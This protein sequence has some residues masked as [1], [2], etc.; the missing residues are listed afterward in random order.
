MLQED[1]PKARAQL[2]GKRRELLERW[3]KGK[4][5]RTLDSTRI[6]RRAERGRAPLSFS[7]LRLWFL[8]QLVPG[9]A[10]YLIPMAMR[11][12]GVLD[13]DAL[14]VSLK[15]LTR[16]HEILRTSFVSVEGQPSQVITPELVITLPLVNLKDVAERERDTLVHKFVFEESQRPFN[17][18]EAPLWR[19]KLLSLDTDDHVL[20]LMM[21]HII[22]DEWSLGVLLREVTALYEALS[23]GARPMLPELPIQYADF[24]AWQGEW[25]QGEECRKQLSYWTN[26]LANPLAVLELPTDSPRPTV[27]SFRGDKEWLSFPPDLTR[28]LKE[29]SRQQ[30]AT[31][32]MTLLTA[33]STLLHRYTGQQS[34]IVG[35]PVA[36]RNRKETEGL[37]GCFVNTLVL[38]TDFSGDPTF[39]E[40]LLRVRKT[41]IDAYANQDLPFEKLVEELQPER[42]LSRNPLCDVFFVFQNTPMPSLKLGG[43]ALAPMQVDH[44]TA[45]LDLTL[46]LSEESDTL[47]GYLEY[48]ADLFLA[49]TIKR[50]VG[51]LNILLE[52]L[53]ANPHSRVSALPL[54]TETE[55]RQLVRWNETEQ[56]YPQSLCLHQLFESQVELS[57]RAAALI[58]DEQQITYGE[59]NCKANQLAHHL[60]GLGVGPETIVAVCMKR[61]IEMVIGLLGILKAG[62]AYLPLDPTYPKERLAFMLSDAG[63]PVVLTQASFKESLPVL[64]TALVCLDADWLRIAQHSE[65]NPVTSVDSQNLAYIIYTSGSTGEPKGVQVQHASVVN[66]SQ[67]HQNVYSVGPNDRATQVARL[68]FDASVWEIWPYLT[69]GASVYLADEW[70][71]T[72]PA[73]IVQWLV[74]NQI[75]ISFLPTPLAHAVLQ[76][77]WSPATALRTMLTGGDVLQHITDAS[78]PF[79]LVNNYGPT[80][81]TVVATWGEVETGDRLRQPSIG[82]PIH[83]TQVH[84]LDQKLGAVPVGVT[85]EIYLGG[86]GLAR[87]YFNRAD[88][89]AERFVP[90]PFSNK[91]GV[92]LYKTGDLGSYLADGRIEFRGRVDEQVKI[93]GYRIEPMEIETAL[94]QHPAV[95]EAVVI[96]RQDESTEKRLIG[97]L[98]FRE[99]R[100]VTADT[101]RN[102]LKAKLPD[103]MIPALFVSLD[104]LPLTPSGKIDRRALPAPDHERPSLK[105]KFVGART[106]AEK[107]LA[108]IWCQ[109]LG[110]PQV[111][112]HDNFFELG[113]DSILSIQIIARAGKAGFRFTPQQ[114]F[115]H[116]TIA[117]LVAV[118]GVGDGVQAEQGVVTGPVPLTP[119]QRWFFEQEIVDPHHYNQGLMLEVKRPLDAARLKDAID[120]LLDHHDGLRLRFERAAEGWRQVNAESA[121]SEVLSQIDEATAAVLQ[122]SLN[123]S[124]GPLLRVA[125]GGRPA[126]LLLIAHHL[127]VDAVSWRILLEDLETVYRQ[128][129]L[130]ERVELPAKTTAFKQW[131]LRLEDYARSPDVR[132]EASYWLAMHDTQWLGLPVDYTDGENTIASEREVTVSIDTERT[133]VLL[134]EVPSVYRTQIN[135]ILLTALL[136]AYARWSGESKLLLDLEGHGREPVFDDLDVTRTIGWFTTIFPVLLEFEDVSQPGLALKTIKEQLRKIPRRG[137]GYGVL[138]YLSGDEEIERQLR[139]LPRAEV[140]FNY[141]GQLDQ[142]TDQ[143]T[144]FSLSPWPVGPTR[145]PRRTREH[146]LE[147][148]AWISGGQLQL[149]W[150][151][152]E[153]I[154]RRET[155]DKLAE[156]FVEALLSLIAHC[157]SVEAGGYTPS[158]FPLAGLGQEALDR[159]SAANRQIEDIYPLSP[160]QQGMLF[161]SLSEP[162]SGVYVTQLSCELEGDLDVDAFELAWQEVINQHAILRTWIAWEGMT[163]PLQVVQR[164]VELKIERDDW[165][166]EFKFSEAPL[167][168]LALISTG[169]QAYQFV[170]SHHHLLLDGWSRAAVLEEVFACYLEKTQG[171]DAT[172]RARRPYRDYIEWLRRQD[173][174]KAKEYWQRV[175]KGFE[176]A[177][178]IG[179]ERE[180]ESKEGSTAYGEEHLNL[181]ETLT[182]KIAEYARSQHLTINSLAL[183]AWAILISRYSG[184]RE[185]LFGTTL[186]GRSMPIEELDQMVGLFINTLP[187]RVEVRE[188]ET[189][190]D[191][192]QYVQEL[193]AEQQLYEY[194]S[195]IQVQRWSRQHRMKLFDSI[196]VFENYPVGAGLSEQSAIEAGLQIRNVR[197][198]E[199]T[200]YPLAVVIVPGRELSLRIGYDQRLYEEHTIRLMLGHLRTILEQLATAEEQ[201]LSAVTLLSERERRETLALCRP[202]IHPT[203]GPALCLHQ[204][205]ELCAEK[206]P[207]AIAVSAEGQTLSYAELNRRANQLAHLLQV[208]GI[209]PEALVVLYLERSFEMIVAM[210]AVLKAGGAYVPL[211]AATP[212]RRVAFII[213]DTRATVVITNASLRQQLPATGAMVICLEEQPAVL[214]TQCAENPCSPVF[215]GNA[216]YV[217]YTSGSTGMPKG[218]LVTHGNVTRLFTATQAAY[219]FC[220]R[221]VWTQF[222]S[223]GFDFSVWEIWGALLYGGR[224]VIVPQAVTRSP[225]EFYRLLIS[226]GVTVLNQT[227]SAFRQLMQADEHVHSTFPLNLRLVIFGGEALDSRN[228]RG[229]FMRHGDRRPQLVNM[230]GITETTVHVTY[231]PLGITDTHGSP[232]GTPL[233]DLSVYVLDHR[234]E[235][236]PVSIRGELY[237]GGA[238]VARG[239]LHRPELTAERFVPDPFSAIEGA[240]LYKSGDVV[241]LRPEGELEYLGRVDQQIKVRGFR[242]EP[243]EIESALGQH[244]SVHEAAVLLREDQAQDKR[245][246]AY[247]VLK[248]TKTK[249]SVEELRR[250]LSES[251]PEY[252]LPSA[253]VFL[254]ELPLTSN[255][256]RDTKALLAMEGVHAEMDEEYVEPQNEREREL[257]KIWERVLGLDQVGINDN[258]FDLGGD[259]ILSL[260][261]LADARQLDLDFS[262]QQLFRHPTI[263]QLVRDATANERS[264]VAHPQTE[265]FSLISEADRLQL[266]RGI[267]DAYPLA[268]LQTGMLFH[269]VY[270]EDSATYH[271]V[272]SL[273]LRTHLDGPK[274][275][276]AVQQLAA[277]HPVLRTSFDLDRF[278]EPLQLIH[279]TVSIPGAIED[280][281]ALT[282]AEQERSLA[283]FFEEERSRRF[284]WT[285]PPLLRFHLHRLSDETFQLSWTEHHAILDGWSLASMLTELFQLYSALLDEENSA[286][287]PLPIVTFRDFVAL[288]REAL[289]SEG[290]RSYWSR[291]LEGSTLTPLPRG[292]SSGHSTHVAQVRSLEVS[293][294]GE[295]CRGLKDVA[296]SALVPLKSVLLAAHLKVLSFISGQ[297]DVLTGLVTNGRPAETGSERVLGLFLNTLP[298]R[299]RLSG[300]TWMELMQEVFAGEQELLPFRRFPLSELLNLRGG[301]P[302]FET[303]FNFVDFHV[304]DKLHSHEIEVLQETSF[305]ET[306][307]TLEANFVHERLL[308]Q[309]RLIL[310]YNAAKLS[311]EQAAAIAGYYQR[312]FTVISHSPHEFHQSCSLLTEHES[313]QLRV[314]NQTQAD[315][316]KELCIH[317]LFEAQA[318]RSPD[319]CAL[320]CGPEQLTYGE[321]DQ[322][323]NLLACYLRSSG[324]GPEVLVGLYLERSTEMLVALLGVLKAGGAYVPLAAE[325]PKER[326]EFM[327]QDSGARVLL[328]QSKL[329]ES[330]PETAAQVICMDEVW[331]QIAAGGYFKTPSHTTSSNLAYLIYTS[332]STGQPKGVAMPHRPLVNLICWQLKRSSGAPLRT[333]Q[334]SPLS[335][336]ASFQ[337]IFSTWC[338]GGTLVLIAE[339]TRRDAAELWRFLSQARIERLFLPFVALQH[340]A[341]AAAVEETAPHSLRQIIT[342]GEQLKITP[343]IRRMFERIPQ[344][345]LDNQ[346]GP[347]ESHVV[348]A[349]MLPEERCE[350][351][352]LP[353]IGRPIANTEVYVLDD[354]MRLIPAG[355]IGQL[356]LGGDALA[357]GY[358]NRPE[359]TAGK[360]VPHPF[361]YEPGMRLYRTGDQ[362]RYL[363]DGQ[364]EFVGRSD[365]QVKVRGFRVELGEIEAMLAQHENVNQAVVVARE[366]VPGQKRLVAYVVSHTGAALM[367]SELRSFLATKLPNY[368]LPAAFVVLEKLA[369]TASGKIDRAA[370]PVPENLR[371]T[372]EQTYAPPRN[373]LE[374]RLARI[375]VE[376]LK[377]ERVGIHDDFF[378]LGGDSL[379]ATQFISRVFQRLKIE[380]PVRM[381]FEN[382]TIAEFGMLIEETLLQNVETLTEQEAKQTLETAGRAAAGEN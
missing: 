300:E 218:V 182:A 18:S 19:A 303:M 29:L 66:L 117:Q 113:G 34:V 153:N 43:L 278:T 77:S 347:T 161:H 109:V 173:Q 289:K 125:Y 145:S 248:S 297:A 259:S 332:G 144:L 221:D 354:S 33:F 41:A 210:L 201:K 171:R 49:A 219:S 336:D 299:F 251:L 252:M 238:G 381:L 59:L 22:A 250:F 333:L 165:R 225:E 341:E 17:L 80:E 286:T 86:A 189:V 220:E 228:L 374:E 265:P 283:A 258:F 287:E 377:L 61:S 179:V 270:H 25:L 195:L 183:G 304:Y 51:H 246:I 185:V 334:F 296:H 155:I 127:I 68:V 318:E 255:G 193:Q 306:D 174:A 105:T 316:P 207:Q 170:W 26:Q 160:V 291:K 369:L 23:T 212:A 233:P 186:S 65:Q 366:D 150:G 329:R 227:P 279:E 28:K 274:W 267:V 346:Y 343:H 231:R 215:A 372:L 239:Y 5:A 375:W 21:H 140:G 240:R 146:L 164:R 7:Q 322:L 172:L 320:L 97:Y 236:V 308:S 190:S 276:R 101:L 32:F 301:Q 178:G 367:H 123:L 156:G 317:H 335:F 72:S 285:S 67:W 351:P 277:R 328:T 70:T 262:L 305:S 20:L 99:S 31:L 208:N 91:P 94:T 261:V 321:L 197:A 340:L 124:V 224:L 121:V 264:P 199:K 37:I 167:M 181:D 309:V 74:K 16:R 353:A 206:A 100:I 15:E 88:L 133:G 364:I 78:L 107:A 376:L 166:W 247:L 108:E 245:L 73:R 249:P 69:V 62:A 2:S 216:A 241:R 137:I 214:D 168:H 200:N 373:S 313:A 134:Q 120:V 339:E 293:L 136:L 169:K 380:F 312:S 90:D 237:V 110:L 280:L 298:F 325:Y 27:S 290:C 103:Y 294:T 223:S 112:I 30:G 12:Q 129:S 196:L 337:E 378:E 324:V 191:W 362:A 345:I 217:I 158:D 115:Q 180:C 187:M 3:L 147:I 46:S 295:T 82:S 352:E 1:L 119:I 284:D 363:P 194:S 282:A 326:L 361:T 205:F 149:S 143:A 114:I 268:R 4:A 151:Y 273:R 379:L 24:A 52:G 349:F 242:I 288:E 382:P 35:T 211:D 63:A 256:K 157:C 93:R 42:D 302:L 266:P 163:E 142:F 75:T 48:S 202:K 9:S 139:K 64:E 342:A 229:W 96:A 348:S 76:E 263:R 350:W 356:Y 89:T 40:L 254:E 327:V 271:N 83:N 13:P 234:M 175:L 360:F 6:Q 92:R 102:F 98:V 55:R 357:R 138:R 232:I 192:L 331:E 131:A 154:H 8:D 130:G 38:R 14:E 319:A 188:E 84:I 106:P 57:P 338:A 85:G 292:L 53:T 260:R 235:P 47:T 45:K 118:A 358:L 209:G 54:L 132:N 371:P 243:G 253:F 368:M 323:A 10:S 307:F 162:D 330:L 126:H 226:E 36:N 222:H 44:A 198:I 314:W 257:A 177:T 159:L 104:E 39:A 116:Q 60:R 365:D 95:K 122:S 79:K 275:Q 281:R 71:L 148:N 184:E 141:L 244:D 269:S 272:N 315:Y 11:L 204:L 56:R 370:L 230:Y 152:S 128:L 135:D 81:S 355:V 310:K 359:L 344:C 213:D 311:D 203:P 176:A 58:C 50:M 111:G 87:G